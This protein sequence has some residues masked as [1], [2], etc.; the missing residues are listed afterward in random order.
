[1]YKGAYSSQRSVSYKDRFSFSKMADKKVYQKLVDTLGFSRWNTAHRMWIESLYRPQQVVK[2]EGK[3]F[4]L[5]K[6]ETVIQTAKM[7]TYIIDY[8]HIIT[9]T[10]VQ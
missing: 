8:E 5:Q 2:Y 7:M 4:D 3:A 9:C 6:Q 1:M 10:I